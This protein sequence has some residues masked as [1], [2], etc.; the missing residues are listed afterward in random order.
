M[1]ER[2][3]MKNFIKDLDDKYKNERVRNGIKN[4]NRNFYIFVP[5]KI[6]LYGNNNES[7]II[8]KA[9]FTKYLYTRGDCRV[10]F[11]DADILMMLLQVKNKT[12]IELLV[13]Y[14]KKVYLG[15]VEKYTV[16]I[17]EVEYDVSGILQI[18]DDQI[19]TN[20][21]DI[22]ISFDELLVL[23]NLILS[24]DITSAPLWKSKP[25][26]LKHTI[27]KYIS[28]LKFYYYGDHRS[29]EY[30]E[31]MGFDIKSDIYS[32]YNTRAKRDEKNNF[33]SD[34]DKFEK[35]GVL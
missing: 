1:V 26:F 8:K 3:K 9:E 27:T 33:F 18:S 4:A 23:I 12:T 16:F 7:Y 20:P 10:Y 35:S 11:S 28:L 15:A 30:L 34:F 21:Q 2:G 5:L 32:N 6:N 13:E 22:D 17:G 31:E 29:K 24:K 14:L 25:D 19:L